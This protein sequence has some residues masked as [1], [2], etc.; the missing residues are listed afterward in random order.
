[1]VLHMAKNLMAQLAYIEVLS[2]PTVD[3]STKKSLTQYKQII[4]IYVSWSS[5]YFM[6][7]WVVRILYKKVWHVDAWVYLST[8]KEKG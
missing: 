3:I 7:S 1:M 2:P 8:K 4:I 6:F 5:Q